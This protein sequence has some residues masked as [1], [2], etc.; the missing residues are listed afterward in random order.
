MATSFNRDGDAANHI[1]LNFRMVWSN[2]R[3]EPM[4]VNRIPGLLKA[5]AASLWVLLVSAPPII[6]LTYH[7]GDRVL[8]TA[9][10]AVLIAFGIFYARAFYEDVPDS[11]YYQRKV[12]GR[13][14]AVKSGP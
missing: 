7:F 4:D 2:R 3:T 12:R 9:L 5:L 1:K 11:E 8:W 14:A 13:K 10:P 6:W